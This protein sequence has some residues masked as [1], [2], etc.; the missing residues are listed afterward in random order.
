MTSARPPVVVIGVG[1][2]MR[3]DDGVGPEVVTGLGRAPAGA[4]VAVCDGEAGRL[5]ELW[6]GRELAVVID[7]VV[8]GSAPGTVHVLDDPELEDVVRWRAGTSSHAAGV[9]EAFALG[10]ALD[11]LPDRLVVVGVEAA[12]VAVGEELSTAVRAA[13]PA[14]IVQVRTLIDH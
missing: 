10:A 12:S 14:V 6:W 11:R 13:I 2:P 9:G 3:G 8:T 7:A 1:N 5:L 4:E